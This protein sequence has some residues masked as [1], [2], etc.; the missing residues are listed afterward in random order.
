[1]LCIFRQGTVD[2]SPPDSPGYNGVNNNTA[3]CEEPRV[4]DMV[5]SDLTAHSKHRN[6]TNGN[7]QITE[8]SDTKGSN[9]SSPRDSG[10]SSPAVPPEGSNSLTVPV[11]QPRRHSD[12]SLASSTQL[13][14][15]SNNNISCSHVDTGLNMEFISEDNDDKEGI[16]KT[17][18]VSPRNRHAP[19]VVYSHSEDKYVSSDYFFF[20]AIE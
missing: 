5:T 16:Q 9:H 11:G 4:P 14:V 7:N 12:S 19:K 10:H 8:S 13:A 2:C 15:P 6:T 3:P 1:M 18:G 20:C 17:G